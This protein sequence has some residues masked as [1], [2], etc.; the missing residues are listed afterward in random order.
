MECWRKVTTWL[1]PSSELAAP[2]FRC[3]GI[4]RNT[5]LQKKINIE[6]E[7]FACNIGKCQS[8]QYQIWNILTP[9]YPKIKLITQLLFFL[10]AESL[11][12]KL[13]C[14]AILYLKL[15]LTLDCN[16]QAIFVNPKTG[17]IEA[18]ADFRKQGE[19][20]GFW[21]SSLINL[22]QTEGLYKHKKHGQNSSNY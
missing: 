2:R 12:S 19:V 20:D 16:L 3:L 4:L 9:L 6:F 22:Q 13:Q 10:G 18:N 1:T 15:S 21:K 17:E 5:I 11:F 14:F 7:M 8:S